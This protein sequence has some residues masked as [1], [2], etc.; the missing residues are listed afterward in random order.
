M[1]ITIPIPFRISIHIPNL[2]GIEIPVGIPVPI[3][4]PTPEFGTTPIPLFIF[5]ISFYLNIFQIFNIITLVHALP[6][7]IAIGITIEI[8]L[9]DSTKKI[10]FALQSAFKLHCNSY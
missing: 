1:S 10:R 2:V 9:S 3:T 4:I 8:L 5:L 7:P 6:D